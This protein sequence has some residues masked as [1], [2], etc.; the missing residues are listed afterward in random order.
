MKKIFDDYTFEQ[1]TSRC[2]YLSTKA[3]WKELVERYELHY[4]AILDDI[5]Y[6]WIHSCSS[7]SSE[8]V[9]IDYY[10]DEVTFDELLKHYQMK[11]SSIEEYWDRC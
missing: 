7:E 1:K 5:I 9:I 2:K 6:K 10:C 11:R 8:H 4:L 3:E